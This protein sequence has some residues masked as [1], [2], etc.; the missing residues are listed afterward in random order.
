MLTLV[1]VS[2]LVIASG[3]AVVRDY[4]DRQQE[5]ADE[6]LSASA[7]DAAFDMRMWLD[8]GY[9]DASVMKAQTGMTQRYVRWLAGE[10]PAF[11]SSG[12]DRMESERSILGYDY[13][14]MFAPD[15]SVILASELDVS[16]AVSDLCPGLVAQAASSDEVVFADRL[17]CEGSRWF[18][19]WGSPM[20][21]A[22][23]GP[24]VAVMVRAVDVSGPA[25]DLLFSAS[26]PYRSGLLELVRPEADGLGLLSEAD[27]FRVFS[28]PESAELYTNL[29]ESADGGEAGVRSGSTAAGVPA[30]AVA[31]PVEGTDWLVVS[32]AP[33]DEI[34]APIRSFTLW[35]TFACALLVGLGMSLGVGIRRIRMSRYRE[36]VVNQ[37]LQEAL[38]VRERLLANV[39]HEL[40]TPLHSIMG[41]TDVLLGGLAGPLNDEQKHQLIMVSESSK[42]LLA[43]VDD[44]LDLS[45]LRAGR[46]LVSVSEFTAVEVMDVVRRT[47][48]PLAERKALACEYVCQVPDLA[49]N[50]DRD[51]LERIM[52]NLM[53][54]AVKFTDEGLVRLTVMEDGADHAVIEVLDTGQGI[55]VE[56]IGLV[57]EEFYQVV[58]PEYARRMGTGL[59][60]AI[61]SRMAR[62]LGGTITVES[63]SGVGSKFSLRIPRVHP[64]AGCA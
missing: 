9:A 1:V 18:V 45:K 32:S 61:S 60:L 44:L 2:T 54:N 53:S 27:D 31:C 22:A 37:D 33:I 19:A 34:D 29:V 16:A 23:G 21:A 10:D 56:K 15:G 51:M 35:V 59:G 30:V 24:V 7:S 39:S 57:M 25:Q 50:T 58:E 42:R 47:M 46:F 5:L 41:F 14:G 52:L 20:R 43:L 64:E 6:R 63:Q 26:R 38:G 48:C 17:C 4:V 40:R 36:H 28:E 49:F 55:P 8:S 12:L 3:V 62:E 13:A 11:P